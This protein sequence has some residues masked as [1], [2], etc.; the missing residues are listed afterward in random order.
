IDMDRRL[1]A[2]KDE[3]V[4]EISSWKWEFGDGTTSDEQ[5]PVH[6]Y[7]RSGRYIV[8]LNIEGPEGKSRRAKVWDVAIKS[9]F[10][11]VKSN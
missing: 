4:G 2:F 8:T 9:S 10:D 3:S 11:K 5:H 1:V 7:Q 6:T